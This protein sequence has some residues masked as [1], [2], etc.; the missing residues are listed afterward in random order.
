M[1][2][3]PAHRSVLPAF[4][5]GLSVV[6]AFLR[7]AWF[8]LK[9]FTFAIAKLLRI[10]C[11]L[12]LRSTGAIYHRA[13]AKAALCE[14]MRHSGCSA[15]PCNRPVASPWVGWGRCADL[16]PLYRN[17][18]CSARVNAR[19]RCRH[20]AAASCRPCACSLLR[21]GS[22][23]PRNGFPCGVSANKRHK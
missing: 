6:C 9:C 10:I 21:C 14:K 20:A 23:N 19:H 18:R 7:C 5:A 22:A 8:A 4:V 3:V 13:F 16:P 15:S 2:S 17:S 11:P 1:R 12:R